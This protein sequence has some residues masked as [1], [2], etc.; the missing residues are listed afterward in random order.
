VVQ[1]DGYELLI[2]FDSNRLVS[3]G[4]CTL[5]PGKSFSIINGRNGQ[6]VQNI[7][8]DGFQGRPISVWSNSTSLALVDLT[9]TLFSEHSKDVVTIQTYS[10]QSDG[11][12]VRTGTQM[13]AEVAMAQIGHIV[14]HPFT[15]QAF[16]VRGGFT[17]RALTLSPDNGMEN[18]RM[19]NMMVQKKTPSVTVDKYYTVTAAPRL[20]F[21]PRNGQ[22][23][24]QMFPVRRLLNESAL[25]LMDERRLIFKRDLLMNDSIYLFDFTPQW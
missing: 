18:C 11:S 16:R 1:Q 5:S 20:T 24:R 12:F 7:G 2:Q 14:V 15:I 19:M 21:P 17:P 6:V 22:E 23:S 3:F 8:W 4:E 10:R 25:M 13:V 9:H